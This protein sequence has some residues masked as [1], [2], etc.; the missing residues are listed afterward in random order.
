MR[1]SRL[2]IAVLLLLVS[3]AVQ[4]MYLTNEDYPHFFDI[5]SYVDHT[6]KLSLDEVIAKN[7]WVRGDNHFSYGYSSANHWIKL[8]LKNIS[9]QTLSPVLWL[10]E[11]F[12]HEV[13]FYDKI[14]GQWF[15]HRS[16]LQI[17]VSQ[18]DTLDTFPYFKFTLE[19]KA[20]RDIYIQLNGDFGNFGGLLLS[21]EKDFYTHVFSKSMIFSA[22]VVALV[23]LSLFYLVLHLYL[24]EKS[25]IYYSIYSLSYSVWVALYNGMIPMFFNEWAHSLLQISMPIAFIFLIKFSQSIMN[26]IQ[27]NPYFHK[28]LN[29][30]IVLYGVAIVIMLFNAKNGFMI[31]NIIVTITMPVLILLSLI[32]L[33]RKDR[34]INLYTVGLFA[35]FSG[36]TILALLNSGMLP[37]NV[38][39]RNAPFPGS[40][41]EFAFFA[42]ILALKVFELQDE[43]ERA[44]Q[45]LSEIQEDNNI[46]LEKQVVERTKQLQTSLDRQDKA[47]KQ[48]SSFISLISH[49]L[50]NPLGII[51]S[52]IALL[53]IEAGKNIDNCQSRISTLAMTT[54]RIEMLF[55]DWLVSDKLENDLFSL[56]VQTIELS[57]K[58]NSLKDMIEKTYSSHRF[59]FENQIVHL[60]VDA[61]LLKLALFNLIDNAVK[62][63][64]AGSLIK[65]KVEFAQ[66]VVNIAVEDQGYGVDIADRDKIFERF[67]RGKCDASIQGSGLGLSLVKNVMELHN[68][69]LYLDDDYQNGSRFVLSFKIDNH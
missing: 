59:Y 21:S 57:E 24:G 53:R 66:G 25:F 11:A 69:R 62:Y 44:N 46:R 12:F 1:N 29:L 68:G 63:S 64:P 34:L 48:Y 13:V 28:V 3:S 56:N 61:I 26:T 36:M 10:T 2:W 39:T 41:I 5:E 45:Y 6:T 31:H 17:P 16:G 33:R 20:E 38:L 43:K 32:S 18:R 52:Q 42:Y 47:I 7:E 30:L 35:Y 14:N 50:R 58:L 67:I 22:I 15:A 23:M 51:K 49:E 4:A 19:P 40:V 60:E 27:K 8:N 9:E 37:Y 54:Q 55:D 65:V